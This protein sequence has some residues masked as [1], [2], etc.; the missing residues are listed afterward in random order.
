MYFDINLKLLPEK[1]YSKSKQTIHSGFIKLGVRSSHIERTNWQGVVVVAV[2]QNWANVILG[3]RTWFLPIDYVEYFLW[4]NPRQGMNYK[5][6]FLNQL[7]L[8]NKLSYVFPFSLQI[9]SQLF[10][11]KREVVVVV[12]PWH[13]AVC[14]D[15]FKHKLWTPKRFFFHHNWHVLSDWAKKS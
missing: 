11:M 5:T 8:T 15:G 2:A 3:I 6:I 10:L 14:R 12:P 9:T 13:S 4:F 1:K 7:K